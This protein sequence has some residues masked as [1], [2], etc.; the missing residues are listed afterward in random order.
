MNA[1]PLQLT[2]VAWLAA[3]VACAADLTLREQVLPVGAVIRLGDVADIADADPDA[4]DRLAALP[5]MPAPAPGTTTMLTAQGV[6]ELIAASG[7]ELNDLRFFGAI[8]IVVGDPPREAAPEPRP[9]FVA[10]S[11]TSPPTPPTKAEPRRTTGY[12]LAPSPATQRPSLS[13]SA[14][15][16][17]RSDLSER[18]AEFAV[19]A[20]G[21]ASVEAALDRVEPRRLRLLSEATSPLTVVATGRIAIGKNRFLISFDTAD[22]PVRF[23][24]VA[25]LQR[26]TPVVVAVRNVPRGALLT[27][28]DVQVRSLPRDTR[29]R[30]D[31]LPLGTVDDVI[32]REAV[33]SLRAGA[34]LTDANCLPPVL[35]RRGDQV[36]VMAG[37]G[38]IRIRMAA[39]ARANGRLGEIV[40]IE[41]IETR[42]QLSAR[43]VG[44]RELAV[45]SATGSA[46]DLASAID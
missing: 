12:R 41:T 26:A 13:Q 37:G 45:L 43:V 11:D 18:I 29:L 8:R 33:R 15:E 21:E 19:D 22:G 39:K 36:T 38:G 32:G 25:D 17:L 44:R 20:L 14:I 23:P 35:V 42:D 28:A 31:E 5:L 3:G 24:V 4:A 34:V 16:R 27:R 2:L 9:T 46:G 30:A 1:K 7:F 6:R 40:P 10:E